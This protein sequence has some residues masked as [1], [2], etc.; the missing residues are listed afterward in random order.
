MANELIRRT[1]EAD[2]SV[3]G[4]MVDAELWVDP[5]VWRETRDRIAEAARGLHDA[6]RAPHTPGTVRANTTI[7]MFHMEDQ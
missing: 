4:L 7:A 3:G 1:A 5:Q 6:A 2:W